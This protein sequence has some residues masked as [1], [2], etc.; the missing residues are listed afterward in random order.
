MEGRIKEVY[1]FDIETL[2]GII[3]YTSINVRTEQI[4]KFIIHSSKD[5]SIELFD[6]LMYEV[7][8]LIG[9]N[10]ESF[11][12]P[13]IHY[14]LIN[15]PKWA[16][17]ETI[18]NITDYIISEL[19]NKAQEI[20][21]NQNSKNRDWRKILREKDFLIPQLDLFKIW[22]YDNLARS[23]SLKA[24]EISMNFHNVMEMPIEHST[25]F[26]LPSQISEIL[27]YNLNDVL[28]TYE[29]YKKTI[30][31][32]KVELRKK[33]KQKYKLPCTNWNNGK[34][35]ENLILKLYCDK[36]GKNPWDVRKLRSSYNEIALIDC[37]PKG[38]NF[39]SKEFN[40]LLEFY[41]NKIVTELKGSVD[42]PLI[43]KGIKYQYGTG[44]LHAAI[45]SGV[46]E[47]D[48]K[49]IIKTL[50][51][52]SLYPN[53]P[54]ANNFY[55]KH[56]G[57]EFLEVYKDD[58]V[59]VRLGEKKKPK[60]EQDPTIIDGY[61]EAANIPYGKSNDINSFL[62]D[63]VY[64]LKTT[65]AGQL[66]ISML[67]ERLC[68]IPDSQML[69]VNTDG[70]EIRIPRQYEELYN[71]I[72]KQW[73]QETKLVLEFDDYS[74]MVIG[75][76]NNYISI[77]TKGKVKNKGRFEV[78]KVIGSEP[79]YHKD[80]SFRIIP[81]AIQEFFINNIPVEDTIKNHFTNSYEKNDNYGIYDFCGRQKFKGQDY[82][83]IHYFIN[84][85]NGPELKIEKQQKHTRYYISTNGA[86][87][88]KQYAK[89]SQE[90]IH[91]GNKVT[92]FNK[93]VEKSI[94]DYCID[95]QFFIREANKEIRNIIN[96]QLE[97]F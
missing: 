19:Y 81:L 95:Y 39:N 6:H 9:Y 84:T 57:P 42:Y 11:D 75:D 54:I 97:L 38:I 36:T 31:F 76:I 22:H 66:F 20:I 67:C 13:I 50:D 18:Y 86:T 69:M 32:N 4:K 68:E 61:K 60:I 64:T 83:Q 41:K 12:Y 88:V 10:N 17:D 74:K 73:E 93:F 56:L 71:S 3:T 30:E 15:Y 37:I 43:Y 63:P 48:E 89:G 45:K 53:L 62:Y 82:G 90:F 7:K 85:V 25:V 70:M 51:V 14:F 80:N 8:G 28:A 5:Q 94:E 47:S 24:L 96:N 16:K 26:I 27:E 91:V 40:K 59:D 23:T 35:G 87:F 92:I 58:I 33:I 77:T 2:A 72:C 52:A 34:I 44:G 1:V 29:F 65:L 78:D 55:I 49:Y 21:E 79:A 46:Y